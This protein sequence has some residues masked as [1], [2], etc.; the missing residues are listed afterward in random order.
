MR[1][2][3]GINGTSEKVSMVQRISN[4]ELHWTSCLWADS[5]NMGWPCYSL[6]VFHTIYL[7]AGIQISSHIIHSTTSHLCETASQPEIDLLIWYEVD[8]RIHPQ[9]AVLE[10]PLRLAKTSILMCRRCAYKEDNDKV[11]QHFHPDEDWSIQSQG[12]PISNLVSETLF[13]FIVMQEP[14]VLLIHIPQIVERDSK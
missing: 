10:A 14:T 9:A 6:G 7:T 3:Q 5:R 12:F 4:R 8:T 11:T 13:P 2:D 1:V